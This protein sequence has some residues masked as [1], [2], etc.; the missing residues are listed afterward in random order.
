MYQGKGHIWNNQFNKISDF[1]ERYYRAPEDT[2]PRPT[3]HYR[4]ELRRMARISY[5]IAKKTL[6]QQRNSK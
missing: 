6:R 1:M 3:E 2:G 4:P 5:K